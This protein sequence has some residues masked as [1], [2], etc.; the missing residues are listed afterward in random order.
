MR[1]LSAAKISLWTGQ[2]ENNAKVLRALRNKLNW[3]LSCRY[4]PPFVMLAISLNHY[5]AILVSRHNS[6]NDKTN[7]GRAPFDKSRDLMAKNHKLMLFISLR[8][9]MYRNTYSHFIAGSRALKKPQKAGAFLSFRLFLFFFFR[10]FLFLQH[11]AFV[12]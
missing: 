3:V 8:H 1:T 7:K 9:V 12:K 5:I 10:L 2:I 11:S 6:G 4:R